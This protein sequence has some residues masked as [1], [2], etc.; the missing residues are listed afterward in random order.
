MVASA[1]IGA[2]LS[3]A[4]RVQ[5]GVSNAPEGTYR[6]TPDDFMQIS[7]LFAR[8]DYGIDNGAGAAWADNFTPGGVFQDPSI[9]AIGREQLVAVA[10]NHGKANGDQEHFHLPS[11]GPIVY[12]DPDHA[13][14]H[15]TVIVVKK[16]GFGVQGGVM[17]TGSYDDTLVRSHGKWVFSYRRVHRPNGDKPAVA[18]PAAKSQPADQ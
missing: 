7:Q 14:V 18:C 6:G 8:Y 3:M 15:S 16:T 11:L 1:V 17:V 9:C 5:A 4:V 12:I 10:N 2:A 13:T